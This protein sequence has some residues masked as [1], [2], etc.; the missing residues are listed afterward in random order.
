MELL[1]RGEGVPRGMLALLRGT[2]ARSKNESTLELSVIRGSVLERLTE[3]DELPAL[4][5]ALSKVASRS[6]SI[7]MK[8]SGEFGEATGRRISVDEAREGRLRDLLAKEPG[9]RPAV[10]ELDLELL[11]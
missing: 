9:L 11:D 1:K 3:G 6:L 10:E 7:E 2:E 5:S 4:E 8:I